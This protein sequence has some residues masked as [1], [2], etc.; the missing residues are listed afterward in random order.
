MKAMR[1]TYILYVWNYQICL[2]MLVPNVMSIHHYHLHWFAKKNSFRITCRKN[3]AKN[4]L[5]IQ[6]CVS[7]LRVSQVRFLTNNYK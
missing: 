4:F 7:L 3:E 6:F 5:F 1:E 2:V